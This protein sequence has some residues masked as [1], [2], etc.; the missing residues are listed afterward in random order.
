MR[1]VETKAGETVEIVM[2]GNGNPPDHQWGQ[3]A[4][5]SCAWFRLPPNGTWVRSEY[6]SY[7]KTIA[8][9]QGAESFVD[10][11]WSNDSGGDA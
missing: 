8:A 1:T 4:N 5:K 9:V 10:L 3:H 11:L 7:A 2:T 6:R